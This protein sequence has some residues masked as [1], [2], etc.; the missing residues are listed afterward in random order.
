MGVLFLL[1]AAK[2][3][4]DAFHTAPSSKAHTISSY[5]ADVDRMVQHLLEKN[6]TAENEGQRELTSKD[7]TEKGWQ[8]LSTISWLQDHL[9]A[10]H[11]DE[12]E[13]DVERGTADLDYELHS[14]V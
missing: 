3:T 9:S 8:K 14:V 6:V 11:H 10:L 12:E 7:S 2:R 4:D 1:E 13:E 5:P